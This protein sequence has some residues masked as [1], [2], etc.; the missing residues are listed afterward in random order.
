[1]ISNTEATTDF[2]DEE[3]KHIILENFQTSSEVLLQK[4]ETLEKE[5]DN[6]SEK[7]SAVQQK[8]VLEEANNNIA[9]KLL[10]LNEINTKFANSTKDESN[11][12]KFKNLTSQIELQVEES[13][14]KYEEIQ[15]SKIKNQKIKNPK[16]KNPEISIMISNTEATID[17]EDEEDKYIILENFQ[18][19]SEVL[20]QKLERLAKEV[21]NISEKISEQ[22]QNEVLEEANNN[23]AKKL[24]ELNKINTKFANSTKDES[25]ITKFKNLTSQIELQVKESKK[26][27]DKI[28]NPT[29]NHQR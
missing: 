9:K 15:E 11:I 4:L 20:L 5:V 16:I 19:L 29:S 14:K 18:T 13:K 8:E 10:E 21:D 3:N 17:F 25:N 23:I 24:L 28:K 6:I 7:I 12:T 1:M 26:K 22:Q 2:Q 27:Y